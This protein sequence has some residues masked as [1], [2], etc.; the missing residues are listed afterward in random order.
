MRAAP[1]TDRSPPTWWDALIFL[2]GLL[3]IVSGSGWLSERPPNWGWVVAGILVA[4]WGWRNGGWRWLTEMPGTVLA[5]LLGGGNPQAR[6][7]GARLTSEALVYSLFMVVLLLGALLGH[8][9]MLLLVFALLAGALVLN[10]YATILVLRQVRGRRTLPDMVF[11]GEPFSVQIELTNRK[12]WLS[13]WLLQVEDHLRQG[14]REHHPNVLFE[15][16]P[17]HSSRFA[18]YQVAASSRGVLDFLSLRISSRYPLG[19]WERGFEL[20]LPEQLLIL[21]RVGRLTGRF[22]EAL[23]T[24]QRTQFDAPARTGVFDEEFHRLREF[25]PG[26]SRRAIHWRT[27]ARRNELMVR[28]Y[29]EQHDPEWLLLVE[30]WLPPQPA[31]TDLERLETVIS[32]VATCCT[33]RARTGR[34]TGLQLLLCGRQFVSLGEPG[35]GLTLRDALESLAL[36]EGSSSPATGELATILEQRRGEASRKL[37]ITTHP[38]SWNRLVELW[39]GLG[40]SIDAVGLE[41]ECP[42]SDGVTLGDLFELDPFPVLEA[43]R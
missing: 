37:F 21:P 33:S 41:F 16:I 42:T 35:Q 32:F 11:A 13:S 2:V 4:G 39:A 9:N 10:G 12:R 22:G 6:R 36:A 5:Y 20:N 3:L 38:A 40:L 27:T 1:S 43:V 28:E 30:L 8:S 34:N 19:L 17:P 15:R 18:S 31:S 25:R 23:R 14:A 7:Y 26:D 29:Q 24:Q